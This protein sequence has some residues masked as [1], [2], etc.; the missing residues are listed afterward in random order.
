MLLRARRLGN[1]EV[2]YFHA[3]RAVDSLA[4]I[5]LEEVRERREET[6]GSFFLT[7]YA[8]VYKN[9]VFVDVADPQ[10]RLSEVS[11]GNQW[12]YFAKG[13]YEVAVLITYGGFKKHKCV[14]RFRFTVPNDKMYSCVVYPD[15]FLEVVTEASAE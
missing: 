1:D 2:R 3:K 11:E 12:P 5:S 13:Q 14:C 15:E 9:L 6:I 4:L 7:S 8:E 10:L